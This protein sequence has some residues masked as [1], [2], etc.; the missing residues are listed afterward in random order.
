MT[1][2]LNSL[3]DQISLLKAPNPTIEPPLTPNINTE[4]NT[5]TKKIVLFFISIPPQV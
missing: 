3:S 5:T 4:K 2:S 1:T